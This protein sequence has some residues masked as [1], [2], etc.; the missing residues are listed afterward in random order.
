VR[1]L[2]VPDY[3]ADLDFLLDH[4][5]PDQPIDLVGHS[6]GGNIVMHYAGVRPQRIRRLVNLEGF[7][8]PATRPTRRPGAMRAGWTRSRPTTAASWTC[9]YDSADGVAAG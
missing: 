8:G 7:G 6:M 2:L 3:L 4:Y 5:A 1:Q 9:G